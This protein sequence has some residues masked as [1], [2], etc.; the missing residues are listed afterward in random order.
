MSFDKLVDILKKLQA[1][2]PV[3]SKR[4]E[5]ATSLSRWETAVGPQIAKHTR[6]IRIHD[7]VLWVE[8]DHPIW[9]TEL[10]YRK[11]QIL[12]A[13]NPAGQPVTQATIK[14]LLFLDGRPRK[15]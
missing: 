15:E 12:T 9:K 6:A 1:K 8:V 2:N 7:G 3:L 11:R 4:V 5:E 10:H 13:L 14:D